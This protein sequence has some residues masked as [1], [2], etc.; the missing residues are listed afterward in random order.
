M[1]LNFWSNV[2]LSTSCDETPNVI[3]SEAESGELRAPLTEIAVVC[4]LDG[5]GY[6]KPYKQRRANS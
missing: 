4:Q 1:P 5:F 2:C 6:L 3:R